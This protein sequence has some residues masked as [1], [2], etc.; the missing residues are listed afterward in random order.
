[1]AL[2]SPH[3]SELLH[4]HAGRKPARYLRRGR[5]FFAQHLQA[6]VLGQASHDLDPEDLWPQLLQ[7]ASCAAPH[8]LP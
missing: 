7:R 8:Y 1:M 6:L 4:D 3:H 5:C 2:L